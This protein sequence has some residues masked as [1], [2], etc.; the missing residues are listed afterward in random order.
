MPSEGFAE[1]IA[2]RV[3]VCDGAMGTM[4]YAGGAFVNRPFDELNLTNPELVASVHRSYGEAGATVIET[5][6]FG[7]NRPKLETCGLEDQL[8]AIN[9]AGV[10]LARDAVGQHVYVAGALGPMGVPSAPGSQAAFD[11][12]ARC[13]REQAEVLADARVDLFMLETYRSVDELVA[14]VTAVRLTTDLPVVAQMTT[15]EDGNAPDGVS[16]EA[17]ASRLVD[18]GATVVG[19]NCGCG[20]A[21]MMETVQRLSAATSA[22]L[23]AQPNAGSPRQV[24]GRTMYLSSP[25]FV[26]SYARRF[27][28]LG[29]R[30][31]GG[32]CGTSPEHIRRVASTAL[33][34]S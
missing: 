8:A 11:E 6:T 34:P 30:L 17:F 12:A 10:Q 19:V 26:A 14:A 32:C 27:I 23:A 28:G 5:N 1:A 20:P 29:V 18:A 3:L 16:P 21:Q 22:P 25:E 4:L 9:R 24:E 7:A 31:V 15:A 2:D 33:Q 13:V